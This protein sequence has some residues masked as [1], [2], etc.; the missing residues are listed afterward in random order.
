MEDLCAG[1]A[2]PCIMDIKA[3]ALLRPA[4]LLAARRAGQGSRS[5]LGRRRQTPL[6]CA[7]L[8]RRWA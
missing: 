5:W 2:Q 3:R 1:Y 8:G 6:P 7:A 4:A